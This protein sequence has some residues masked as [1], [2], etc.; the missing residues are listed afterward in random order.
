MSKKLKDFILNQDVF[1][2]G[3]SIKFPSG[4]DNHRTMTGGFLNIIIMFVT[5]CYFAQSVIV[6]YERGD[7][8]FV[9]STQ[10]NYYNPSNVFTEKDG[11]QFAVGIFQDFSPD[12]EL[13]AAD[14]FEVRMHTTKGTQ[15]ELH[16]CSDEELERIKNGKSDKFYRP[17][18]ATGENLSNAIYAATETFWMC[19]DQ[20]NLEIF[21]NEQLN[22]FNQ[23]FF[24][25]NIYQEFCKG[26]LEY[27][28]KLAPEHENLLLGTYVT[29][30]Y[31]TKRFDQGNYDKSSPI[32]GVANIHWFRFP[33]TPFTDYNRI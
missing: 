16:Y 29:I 10:P 9:S 33:S 26:E 25:F 20:S 5:W 27:E 4:E 3:I 32:E 7:T 17:E 15:F 1:G 2:T 6:L 30:L 28:C 22:D 19:A 23:L 24:D 13:A 21:G 18:K 31:N 14:L 12:A 11:L 8:V